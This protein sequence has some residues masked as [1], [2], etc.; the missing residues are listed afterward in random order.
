MFEV[1]HSIGILQQPARAH[2]LTQQH[3]HQC[4][5]FC[6]FEHVVGNVYACTSSGKTH[7]CD[8]NCTERVQLD[9]YSSVCRLSRRV[10]VNNVQCLGPSR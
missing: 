1:T 3:E 9:S 4:S 10:F 6:S 8:A 7:V 5:R 2:C